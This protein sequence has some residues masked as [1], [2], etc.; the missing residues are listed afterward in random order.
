MAVLLE[1]A[2]AA[3]SRLDARIASSPFASAWRLR[4]SWTGY[5]AALK[6]QQVPLEELDIIAEHCGVR[7]PGR[8]VPV[9]A[10]RPLETYPLWLEQIAQRTARHWHKDLPF[11]FAEPEGWE[12]APAIVRALALLDAWARSDGEIAPWLGFPILMRNMGIT[13]CCLPCLVVGDPRLRTAQLRSA[14][15]F[16][17][18]LTQLFRSAD[19]GL[20][21][22]N[23]FEQTTRRAAVAIGRELQ[24][25][26][27]IALGRLVFSH[28]CLAACSLAPLLGSTMSEA[29]KLLERATR[30]GILV[31]VSKYA[32][33][34][35]YVT[36]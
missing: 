14:A 11:T 9:T 36:G 25:G 29:A 22:L 3:V 12:H 15:L 24:P 6:L 34:P 30:L 33:W 32:A 31:E 16:R 13:T 10:E 4:A 5:A 26:N 18:L 8:G 27:L 20:K 19:D 17:H 35:L 28:P 21:R 23:R 2:T 1:R 7:V